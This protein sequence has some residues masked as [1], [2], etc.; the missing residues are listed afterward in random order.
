MNKNKD[1]PPPWFST[2]NRKASII[3]ARMR[4][5]CSPLA[6]HLYSFIHVVDTPVCDCGFR[7]ENNKHFLLECPLYQDERTLMLEK[8]NLI[9]FSP[10]LKNLLF[11]NEKYEENKNKQAFETIQEFINQTGRFN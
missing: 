10:L 8:L 5:L 2:G 1:K 7:R 4:M 9:G 11:G 6:E 3:H